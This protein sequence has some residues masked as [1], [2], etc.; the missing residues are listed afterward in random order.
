MSVLAGGS[1]SLG[2]PPVP[3]P[4]GPLAPSSGPQPGSLAQLQGVTPPSGMLSSLTPM[5]STASAAS[6]EHLPS[7][8]SRGNPSS[9]LPLVQLREVA[10][11]RERVAAMSEAHRREM[12]Q[13]Q[14]DQEELQGE[15]ERLIV[16]HRK[17]VQRLVA[18]SREA[19]ERASAAERRLLAAGSPSIG[20]SE[21]QVCRRFGKHNL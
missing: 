9:T 20:V 1:E 2:S 17:E 12:A 7:G 8:D 15:I 4:F 11:L 3:A 19:T 14:H 6:V 18:E 21:R 16:A 13:A 10:E 5:A